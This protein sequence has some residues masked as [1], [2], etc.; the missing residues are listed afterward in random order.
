[1]YLVIFVFTDP[2][3]F[4][5][6]PDPYSKVFGERD[7]VADLPGFLPPSFFS[8]TVFVLGLVEKTATFS[9][10]GSFDPKDQEI[11]WPVA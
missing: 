8:D 1:M 9:R 10:A 6:E 3:S 7:Y 11:L 4:L 2:L 5:F